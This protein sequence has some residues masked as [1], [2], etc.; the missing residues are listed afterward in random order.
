[1]NT[2]PGVTG[3]ILAGGAGLRM[4]GADKGLL[5]WQGRPLVEHVARTLRNEVDTLLISCNRNREYYSSLA[6]AIVTDTRPGYSGPLAGIEAAT[7]LLR[8]EFLLISPCDTPHL[9]HDIGSRLL[10]AMVEAADTTVDISYACD[11]EREHYLCAVLRTR[12][13][14]TLSPELDRGTRAVRHWYR[15]HRCLAV[16]FSSQ[17]GCFHNINTPDQA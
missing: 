12:I 3:L 17:R 6:D 15:Q 16:D 5:A 14:G 10:T 9:P 7:P 4:G 2:L 1:M 8:S 11:G 13:L